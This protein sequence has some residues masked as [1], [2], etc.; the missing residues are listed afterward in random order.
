MVEP[1][2][3]LFVIMRCMLDDYHQKYANRSDEEIRKRIAEKE[4]E[5]VLIRDI[6]KPKFLS[7]TLKIAVMG[8][9]ERR[10]VAGHREIFARVFHKQVNITTF[11]ITTDHLKGEEDVV[12]HDCTQLLPNGP[13]DIT[14]AH[15]LLRFIPKEKQWDLIMNSFNVLKNGGMA[16]HVL[17]PEDC[18]TTE[19]VDLPEIELMLKKQNISTE[20]IT[21][22]IGQ[23][24]VL[25]K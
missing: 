17:D 19:L 5:L 7:D 22:P 11:D 13:Y 9:G 24:L 2:S 25:L 3:T 21:L 8:C 14:Y 6:V 10:F 4:K 15:V 20:K 1:E 12:R 18:K 16:I 23:A